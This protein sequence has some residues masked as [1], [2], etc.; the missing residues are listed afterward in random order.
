ME[1]IGL[2]IRDYKKMRHFANHHGYLIVSQAFLPFSRNT[3]ESI[4]VY[5]FHL[6]LMIQPK[7]V[8]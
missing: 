6:A 3:V 7:Q 8:Y 5:R 4:F 1:S 2:H